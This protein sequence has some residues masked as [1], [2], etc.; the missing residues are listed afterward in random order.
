MATFSQI[1]S[2]DKSAE[3]M[4]NGARA[5]FSFASQMEKHFQS[6]KAFELHDHQQQYVC[7]SW[8]SLYVAPEDADLVHKSLR[9]PTVLVHGFMPSNVAALKYYADIR[10]Y[11]QKH[12]MTMYRTLAWPVKAWQ[13]LRR[14]APTNV[15]SNDQLSRNMMCFA[16][17]IIGLKE[18]KMSKEARLK[19]RPPSKAQQRAATLDA[20]YPEASEKTKQEIA[21]LKQA[22]KQLK[23]KRSK[24]NKQEIRKLKHMMRSAYQPDKYV[25]AHHNK[26]FALA[27]FV[28]PKYASL[29]ETEFY[30]CKAVEADDMMPDVVFDAS[31]FD[32]AMMVQILRGFS[33]EAE[34][35]EYIDNKA[36]HD[37]SFANVVCIKL[38]TV[39]ELDYLTTKE[40]DQTLRKSYQIKLQQEVV[41]DAM[42]ASKQTEQA[43][44]MY[45][46]MVREISVADD[47][48]TTV[49]QTKGVVT[50][51]QTGQKGVDQPD[52][53]D[54][55]GADG[56]GA[57]GGGGGGDGGGGGADSHGG[58]GG[59]KEGQPSMPDDDDTPP[60]I[61][62]VI[63][64]PSEQHACMQVLDVD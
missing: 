52:G 30:G 61:Q 31:M 22:V 1:N 37:L 55:H 64:T 49:S 15:K 26:Y 21:K 4:E 24:A 51:V 6:D 5:S 19:D 58:G 18:A 42:A 41:V 45:P 13:V 23:A 38:G 36:K 27:W 47:G 3:T 57:A 9:G 2:A 60:E 62:H 46:E 16:K 34:C 7:V 44:E 14:Y 32:E 25:M 12:N 11:R 59:S 8:G 53:A 43:A 54:S 63:S 10:E 35:T 40:C 33:T 20:M 50:I 29:D 56:G 39:D 48:T 28:T 17:R